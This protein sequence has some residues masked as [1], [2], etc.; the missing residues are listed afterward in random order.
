MRAALLASPIIL[1]IF[2]TQLAFSQEL[3]TNLRFGAITPCRV[4]DTRPEGGK[5]GAFGQPA[6]FGG[7]SRTI[8]IPSSGCGLPS[9]ARAY[10]LNVTLVPV[11]GSPIA[12]VTLWPSG[13]PRPLVNTI[14]E[15]RGRVVANSAIIAAGIGGSIDI[16]SSGNTDIII[17]VSGY[18]SDTGTSLFYPITSCRLIETRTSEQNFG[19]GAAFGPPTMNG[20]ETRVFPYPPGVVAYLRTLKPIH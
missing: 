10:A 14:V 8:P 19:Y 1:S 13:A 6:F 4:M 16:Y 5:T 11:N 7:A 17:D 15:P 9:S 3:A 18:F 20:G 12:Q 2:S